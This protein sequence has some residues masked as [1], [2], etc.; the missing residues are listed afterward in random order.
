[1]KSIDIRAGICGTLA[2]IALVGGITLAA[3]NDHQ[4]AA[5]CFAMASTFTGYVVGL[6]S[7]PKAATE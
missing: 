6:Y 2:A 5:G 7:D 3:M 1:M 4:A